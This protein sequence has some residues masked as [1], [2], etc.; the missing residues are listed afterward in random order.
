MRRTWQDWVIL[1]LAVAMLLAPVGGAA[2]VPDATWIPGLYDGADGDEVLVLVWDNTPAVASSLVALDAPVGA[3]LD[4]PRLCP[5][6]IA[7]VPPAAACRA[8]PHP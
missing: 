3:L 4:L 8:P 6:P 7:G 5:T 1:T 2:M